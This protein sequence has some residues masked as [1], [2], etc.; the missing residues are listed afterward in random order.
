MHGKVLEADNTAW[1]EIRNPE[2]RPGLVILDGR[3]GVCKSCRGAQI[4]KDKGMLL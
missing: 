2:T 1:G 4:N 3:N